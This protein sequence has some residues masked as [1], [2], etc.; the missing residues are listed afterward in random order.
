MSDLATPSIALTGFRTPAM[1]DLGSSIALTG[2]RT[3]AMSDFVASSDASNFRIAHTWN[4]IYVPS[5]DVTGQIKVISQQYQYGP[6]KLATGSLGV[7][8]QYQYGPA[9]LAT[10]FAA[11]S[12]KARLVPLA[13]IFSLNASSKS[14]FVASGDAS[15]FRIAHT[16]NGIFIPS[17]NV[18]GLLPEVF[19][20]YQYG[21]A[22]LAAG[23]A[24]HKKLN[25]GH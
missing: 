10:G 9:S 21:P 24:P 6:A 25:S 17:M 7:A 18:T 4:G 15:N 3:P 5:M 8:K 14:S 23:L 12:G 11:V 19:R 13:E 22:S 16:W 1:S 20:Q 2:F